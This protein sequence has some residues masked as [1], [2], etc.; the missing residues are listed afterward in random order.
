[1]D[2]NSLYFAYKRKKNLSDKVRAHP[3]GGQ[4]EGWV[5]KEREGPLSWEMGP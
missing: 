4:V 2:P 1:M 3:M 5:A